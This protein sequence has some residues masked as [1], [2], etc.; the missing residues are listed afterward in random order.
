MAGIMVGD[1]LFDRFAFLGEPLFEVGIFLQPLGRHKDLLVEF[2]GAL[3]PVEHFTVAEKDFPVMFDHRRAG[4]FRDDDRFDFIDEGFEVGD[5]LFG[6]CLNRIKIPCEIGGSRAAELIFGDEG[7][8]TQFGEDLDEAVSDTCIV[9]VG[10]AA[11]EDRD[12]SLATVLY[13]LGIAVEKA[14]FAHGREEAA[15]FDDRDGK[16]W[17][18]TAAFGV[19]FEAAR[20]EGVAEFHQD[21]HHLSVTQQEEESPLEPCDPKLVGNICPH[22]FDDHIGRQVVGADIGAGSAEEA[23]LEDIFGSLVQFQMP[24]LVGTQEIDKTPWRSYFVG[25][26]LVDGADGNTFSAF[27]AI[28]AGGGEVEDLFG[29]FHIISL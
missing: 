2:L 25:V 6:Q 29:F 22:L 9:I 13:L 12:T 8:D 23:A 18:D 17:N 21:I 24:L 16:S 10:Q 14:C 5:I 3:F 26:D 15:A 11:D 20:S 27:D 28:V 1:R 4:R 19:V 7:I